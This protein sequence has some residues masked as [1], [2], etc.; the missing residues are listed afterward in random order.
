MTLF[1]VGKLVSE[2][3]QREDNVRTSGHDEGRPSG[4]ETDVDVVI[5]VIN[6]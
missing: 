6:Q 1:S 3:L 4:F 2:P 5:R